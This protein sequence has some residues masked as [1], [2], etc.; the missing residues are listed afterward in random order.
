MDVTLYIELA[1]YHPVCTIP[2]KY[3]THIKLKYKMRHLSLP[4][5]TALRFVHT[6]QNFHREKRREKLNAQD[7]LTSHKKII[8]TFFPGI[9]R[10][11]PYTGKGEEK[12]KEEDPGIQQ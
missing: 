6:I 3:I 12:V 9:Q 10:P 7:I 2:T 5:T 8:M 11:R 4:S 1:T